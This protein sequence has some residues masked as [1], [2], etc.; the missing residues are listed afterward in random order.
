MV[1]KVFKIL[2]TA[3]KYHEVTE[4]W[5]SRIQRICTQCGRYAPDNLPIA[6]IV[7]DLYQAMGDSRNV[8]FLFGTGLVKLS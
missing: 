1:A 3:R 7:S 8:R 2:I 4:A 6:G 5:E